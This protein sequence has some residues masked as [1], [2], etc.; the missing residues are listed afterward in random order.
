MS[1]DTTRNLHLSFRAKKWLYISFIDKDIHKLPTQADILWYEI[2]WFFK[3]IF[4]INILPF[5]INNQIPNTLDLL[6]S[7]FLWFAPCTHLAFLYILCGRLI[8]SL[9]CYLFNFLEF[10]PG[11]VRKCHILLLHNSPMEYKA[12]PNKLRIITN[13]ILWYWVST[14]NTP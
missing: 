7:N 6:Y 9:L 14:S 8:L 1:E 3:H 13:T 2:W 10:F 12:T 4:T 5:T 11:F